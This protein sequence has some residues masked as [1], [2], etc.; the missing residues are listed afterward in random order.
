M[1]AEPDRKP[2]DRWL[3]WSFVAFFL[4]VFTANGIMVYFALSS[5]TGLHGEK[6]YIRG[7]AYNETLDDVARQKAMGWKADLSL[8]P[9]RQGVD[10]RAAYTLQVDLSDAQSI[11]VSG[12]SMKASFVRPTHDG[13]DFEVDLRDMG[14]GHYQ[15]IVVAPLPGQWDVYVT[16]EHRSGAYRL[17]KRVVVPQ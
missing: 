13:Y 4:V 15:G 2:I 16:A 7:L 3:P 1:S 6:Q 9:R 14:Q 12:A 17:T 5:W 11:G 10:D 8:A